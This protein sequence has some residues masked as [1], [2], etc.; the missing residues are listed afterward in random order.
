[1]TESEHPEFFN[2]ASHK[3][4][5]SH[6]LLKSAEFTL[7]KNSGEQRAGRFLL[8]CKREIP[9]N[10]PSRLGITASKRFGKAHLR[11]RFKRQVRE[12]FRQTPLPPS[13]EIN[14]IPRKE[15]H[16]A[17][18]KEIQKELEVLLQDS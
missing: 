10:T 17:T 1:M 4:P 3:F 5:K 11:N 14:I 16:K 18:Q 9:S 2:K 13:L 15:A 6:R 8:I 7:L 12:A